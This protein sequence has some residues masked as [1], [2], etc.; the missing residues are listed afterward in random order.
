MTQLSFERSRFQVPL[1]L[2]KL[3]VTSVQKNLWSHGLV[4][5][6]RCFISCQ[7]FCNAGKRI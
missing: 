6:W 5:A 3:L 4:N 7:V 1:N 2:G